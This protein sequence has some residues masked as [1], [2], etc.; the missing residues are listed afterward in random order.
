M[1]LKRY[2]NRITNELKARWPDLTAAD[3][4]Y[5]AGDENKL[6]EMVERRRHI[7]ADDA[8]R[9][10]EDFLNSLNVRQRLA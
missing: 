5:I 6:I 7:S 9:D 8:R 4:T 10:V 3:L 1:N 2:W